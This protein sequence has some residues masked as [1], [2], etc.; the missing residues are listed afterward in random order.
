MDIARLFFSHSSFPGILIASRR[1]VVVTHEKTRLRRQRQ[2]ALDRAIEITRI[3]AGEIG[4]GRA[5]IGHEHG[6]A[7]EDRIPDLV[8]D[9]GRRVAGRVKHLRFD[10]A[11]L[12]LFAIPEQMIELRAVTRYVHGIEDRPKDALHI[13]D[14]LAY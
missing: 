12:E 8:G 10:V 14:V 1:L 5:K 11:N 7:D 2:N 13:L 3:T 6:I 9:A 4:A